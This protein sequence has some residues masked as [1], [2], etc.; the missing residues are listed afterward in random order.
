MW[1]NVYFESS[2]CRI[3]LYC[4]LYME[5]VLLMRILRFLNLKWICFGPTCLTLCLSSPLEMTS[6]DNYWWKFRI[7]VNCDLWDGIWWWMMLW[8]SR[9]MRGGLSSWLMMLTE[10]IP[11]LILSYSLSYPILFLTLSPNL[12]LTLA[13]A[14]FC[15]RFNPNLCAC[16]MPPC[17]LCGLF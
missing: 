3:W 11:Y 12:F 14:L 6:G 5:V 13:L 16:F 2:W 10:P 1:I 7:N 8:W 4:V 9:E 15:S 17:W